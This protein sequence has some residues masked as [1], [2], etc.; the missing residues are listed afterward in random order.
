MIGSFFIYLFPF[1][2]FGLL[3][4]SLERL[5]R[6]LGRLWPPFSLGSPWALSGRPLGAF[7]SLW[8]A[9]GRS[10]ALFGQPLGHTGNFIENWTSFTEKCVKFTK[11][12]SKIGFCVFARGSRRSGGMKCCSDPPSTRAGGQDY[13]S[14]TNSLK[15]L[16]RRLCPQAQ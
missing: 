3:W 5:W 16:P 12:S 9:L 7:G 11:L 4:V 8:P 14:F 1:G 13:V 10:L 6:P 15:I 2:S